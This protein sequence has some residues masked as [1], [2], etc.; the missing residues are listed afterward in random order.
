[1]AMLKPLGI[2]K[3]KPLNPDARQFAILEEAAKV[4]D[5]MARTLCSMPRSDLRSL[6]RPRRSPHWNWVTLMG[7]DQETPTYSQL[8]ER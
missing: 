1:M 2:E 6:P 3:G 7:A 4:G 8:D 5:A